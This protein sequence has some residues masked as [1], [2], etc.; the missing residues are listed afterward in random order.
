METW[1]ILQ[2][3]HL[4]NE[5]KKKKKRRAGHKVNR[6]LFP[7]S[8]GRLKHILQLIWLPCD[9]LPRMHT[10]AR[11][12]MH[13]FGESVRLRPQ[14]QPETSSQ[15][16]VGNNSSACRLQHLKLMDIYYFCLGKKSILPLMTPGVLAQLF[17]VKIKDDLE[18]F[19]MAPQ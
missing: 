13:S 8:C 4:R 11:P 5:E 15:I 1:I 10:A 6:S 12:T 9:P 18:K 17:Y 16:A 14:S 3:C 19:P 2:D 7:C